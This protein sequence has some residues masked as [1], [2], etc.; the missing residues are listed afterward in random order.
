MSLHY[1]ERGRHINVWSIGFLA[2]CGMTASAGA[3]T[4]KEAA[5]GTWVLRGYSTTAADGS[6]SESLGPSPKGIAFF[7]D[8]NHFAIT[9][10]RSDLPKFAVSNRE[11]GTA[12]ENAAVVR[13]SIAYFGTY[14]VDEAGKQLVF[15]IEGATLPNWAGTTQKRGATMPTRD[16]LTLINAAGS[17]G[18]VAEIKWKR[19]P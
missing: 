10:M 3:Q 19:A 8:D 4:L 15:S 16:E 2:L 13:G 14:S 6:R 7:D 17:G 9:I 1:G 18:G 5:R 12:V 11:K